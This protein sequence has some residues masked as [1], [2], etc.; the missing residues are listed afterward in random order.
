MRLL[1]VGAV[2]THLRKNARSQ[3]C[4]SADFGTDRIAPRDHC[5]RCAGRNRASAWLWRLCSA[6][7]VH[8][9]EHAAVNA[10]Y[11]ARNTVWG[12]WRNAAVAKNRSGSEPTYRSRPHCRGACAQ[13][14]PGDDLTRINGQH[15]QC[16]DVFWPFKM[17]PSGTKLTSRDVRYSSA[18]QAMVL[19]K[20]AGRRSTFQNEQ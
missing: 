1:I 18:Y 3:R 13:S 5:G 19:Q 2:S 11:A 17:S 12:A 9:L 16:V 20:S 14:R 7:R 15:H 4:G 10:K 6:R 8:A